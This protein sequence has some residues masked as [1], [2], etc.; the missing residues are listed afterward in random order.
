MTKRVCLSIIVPAF[1]EEKRLPSTLTASIDY[2]KRQ[3]YSYEIIVVNDGSVDDTSNV[4]NQFM[5]SFSK[6]YLIEYFPNKG[7]GEA[8]KQG[9][10][11]AKGDM[12]LFMD[13]DGAVSIKFLENLLNKIC[14]GYGVAVGSRALKGSKIIK[15]QNVVR[16][17]LGKLYGVITRLITGLKTK[18]TQCGFKLFTREASDKIFS[19]LNCS[20]QLFDTE[21][22]L[23]ASKLNINIAEVPVDWYH[24]GDSRLTYNFFSSLWVLKEL[25]LLKKRHINYFL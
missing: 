9:M 11:E 23:I 16:S 19:Q 21:I 5:N 3:R 24:D 4:V 12:C 25:Y 22:F 14:E 8:V 15:G 18:D 6:L 13:A 2:L 20:H 7:K 1:N 10:L 17:I